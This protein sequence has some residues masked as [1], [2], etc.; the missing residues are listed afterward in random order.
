MSPIAI[1]RSYSDTAAHQRWWQLSERTKAIGLLFLATILI[2]SGNVAQVTAVEKVGTFTMVALRSVIAVLFLLPFA[3]VELRTMVRWDRNVLP[4][5]IAAALYFAASMVA[6]QAG[7]VSTTATNIGFLINMSAVFVPMLLWFTVRE[8]PPLMAW[9]AAAVAVVGAYLV[10]GAGGLSSTL[11]DL[12]CLLAG[13]F[14]AVWIIALGV[15][16]PKCKAPA[17][18]VLL[19]YAASAVC[20]AP[21]LIIE[22]DSLRALWTA[23]PE[24]L[25]LGVMSSGLGFLFSTRAQATLPTCMVAVVFCFEAIVSAVCGR[26]VLGEMMTLTSY[27]GATL[28]IVAVL[29]SQIQL[30]RSVPHQSSALQ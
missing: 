18:L 26:I 10:T 16:V 24:A 12:L 21:G 27:I 28:I 15:L 6:Q 19:M 29:M 8:M 14:D 23:M 5:I 20:A 4:C 11:G 9:P 1:D 13:L 17:C 7:A 22:G 2:G 30:R 3:I 25:W